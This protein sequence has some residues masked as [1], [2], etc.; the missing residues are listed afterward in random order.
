MDKDTFIA[1]LNAGVHKLVCR[2]E[3]INT[4]LNN[5]LWI[6]VL[7]NKMNVVDDQNSTFSARIFELSCKENLKIIL[8]FLDTF[9]DLLPKVK[10]DGAVR[11][12]AKICELLMLEYFVKSTPIFVD[13][14][15]DN[16]LKKIIEAGFDWIIA[17]KATAIQV[18]TMQTLFLLG[19]KYEWIH[20]E[21]A[22]LIEQRIPTGSTAYKNRGRKVLKAIAINSSLKL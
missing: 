9:C 1:I 11:P 19:T 4:C 10:F 13:T 20:A 5:Q 15:S 12:C 2:D 16:H 3:L 8:P 14:L 21:L 7:L 6:T 22:L 17:N 18:Y